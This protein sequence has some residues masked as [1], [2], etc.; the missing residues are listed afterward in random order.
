MKIFNSQ[1][2]N[3]LKVYGKSLKRPQ[4]SLEAGR[5]RKA[6]NV[7]ISS[8]AKLMQKAILAVRQADDI[9]QD[10]VEELRQAIATGAYEVSSDKVAEQIIYRALVDKL[11]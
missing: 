9:R 10:K 2:Q 8:E 5:V 7:M 6:D 3:L 11:V 1:V 4:S